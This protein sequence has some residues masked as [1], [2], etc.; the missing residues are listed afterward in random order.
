MHPLICQT[1]VWHPLQCSFI[2]PDLHF[3]HRISIHF[4]SILLGEADALLC[5]NLILIKQKGF[6][7]KSADGAVL[8][9]A[10]M[11]KNIGSL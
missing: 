3:S 11:K 4:V 8:K 2:Y 6:D 10:L 1:T 7:R 9:V 5:F